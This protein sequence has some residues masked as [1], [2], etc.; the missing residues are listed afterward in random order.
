[1]VRIL[2]YLF[3]IMRILKKMDETKTKRQALFLQRLA[4]AKDHLLSSVAGLDPEV[5][6]SEPVAG[7]WTVKDIFG[8][9][10]SWNEEFRDDIQLIQQGKHPGYEHQISGEDDFDQ[11]NQHQIELKSE[12]T[13]A[14]IREDIDRDYQ[15][16]V[17]LIL[18]LEPAEYR[19]R[20]VTPWKKAALDRPSVLTNTDTESIETLVTYHWRHMNQ[21]A[22]MIEKWRKLRGY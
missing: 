12:W 17:Q 13:W 1:M 16:A 9:I 11:W 22:G 18:R 8:H 6:C 15:K 20:G 5:L 14:R 19:K 3:G 2:G 21:H 7:D 10:V 4:D